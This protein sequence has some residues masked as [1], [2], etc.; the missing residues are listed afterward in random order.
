MKKLILLSS[1]ILPFLSAN[2][3]LEVYD[4]IPVLT[5]AYA[6]KISRDG[7]QIV[8][9]TI[10][11]STAYYNRISGQ[12]YYYEGCTHGA[13][14]V[15]AD[16]GWI[17]GCQPLDD[18][19]TRAIIMADGK[20]IYPSVFNPLVAGDI[21]SI[22]P[23]ASRICGVIGNDGR[24]PSYLPFY[25][26]IDENG[27]FGDLQILPTPPKDFFNA[28]PQYCSATWISSDGKTIAGQVIQARGMFVY[29]I[30]YTQDQNGEWSYSCPSESLFNPENLPI[31]EPVGDF[32]EEF[33]DVPYPE[34]TN[35]MTEEEK[36][37]WNLA[38]EQ[39]QNGTLAQDPYENLDDYMT[40][41]EVDAFFQAALRYND[42]VYLYNEIN[43]KYWDEM[44]RIADKSVF[45]VRNAMA[46]SADGKWLASSAQV[47]D[48]TDPF[49]PVAFYV[50]YLFNL[51]T[52]ESVKIGKDGE[53]LLPNQ[54]LPGGSVIVSSLA[55]EIIPARSWIYW[56]DSKNMVSILD[57]IDSKNP[58]YASW[59]KDSL[60][61][62]V[63]TGEEPDGQFDYSTLT[64]T[65]RVSASDDLSVIC[66]GVDGYALQWN[67]FLS[68][69]FADLPATGIKS[70]E[71]ESPSDGTYRAFN[72]QGVKV[73]ETNN[74][75][76]ISRLP[77]GLYIINGKKKIIR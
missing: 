26:D 72:L 73:M 16:N 66:G 56:N 57:Y 8:A 40:P 9:E 2:A 47:E 53:N 22:T 11:M 75:E 13:G 27:N 52:G 23:D 54:V 6:Q 4:G 43:E 35:F 50:P 34:Y 42:A 29:P 1:V 10:D 39:W 48:A 71:M 25:C 77:A 46:L 63:I 19:V 62:D 61:G 38:L 69:I 30:I 24:G 20:I 68:Y 51:E 3:Q 65:G 14:Y 18:Q 7:A 33:P 15:I 59:I 74:Q 21:H 49:N 17:V 58:D 60:T 45:F 37:A 64:I 55:S 70:V 5:D 44:F 76:D 67:M 31:P 32:E 28:A 36:I 41:E 12:L